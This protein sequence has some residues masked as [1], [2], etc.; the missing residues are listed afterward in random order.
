MFR[1]ESG[2]AEIRHRL[3]EPYRLVAITACQGEWEMSHFS[4]LMIAALITGMVGFC[5]ALSPGGEY[6]EENIGLRLLFLNRGVR[7]APQEV[8]LV[9]IDEQT[10]D[11]LDMH[12]YPDEWP[13]SVHSR[14]V[15]S[16]V[17]KGVAAIAFDLFFFESRSRE[18]DQEFADTLRSA[19]NVVL[20]QTLAKDMVSI[21]NSSSSSEGY[22]IAER[23][24]SPLPMFAEAAA[25]LAPFP[26][27]K[28]PVRV[29]QFW[30]FRE[31][32]SKPTL[33]VM[34]F[35]IYAMQVHELFYRLFRE[36]NPSRAA[37]F[38]ASVKEIL[39]SGGLQNFTSRM[40][41]VFKADPHLSKRMLK[42]IGELEALGMDPKSIQIL[43]AQVKIYQSP[44]SL[45]INY[46][47]PP[48]TVT[49]IP[50][51]RI[52]QSENEPNVR[53][54]DETID[55]KGKVAFVGLAG[56]RR[57]EQRDGFNT[58]FSQS[59]GM[60]LSGV[61]IAATAFANILEDMPVRPLKTVWIVTL[62]FC[63]GAAT[64]I[65]CYL[66]STSVGLLVGPA[67]GV[68]YFSIASREF[69]MYA[70][71]YPIV[72]PLL[73]QAPLAFF[74]VVLWKYIDANHERNN[75]RR[76]FG[77]FLP[78]LIVDQLAKDLSAMRSINQTVYGVCLHTD[79]DSYVTLS[80]GMEPEVLSAFLNRYYEAVFR[81]VKKHGGMVSDI[82]G[83]SMMAVWIA[84]H[85]DQGLRVRSCLAALDIEQAVRRFNSSSSKAQLPTRIG[86]HYGLISIG[87]IG[88]LDHYEYRPVGDVVNTAAR[89][90]GLNK[91]LGTRVLV[92]QQVIH[93]LDGFLTR[94]VGRF[95]LV[96]KSKPMIL[97][98]LMGLA[99]N[100]DAKMRELCDRFAGGLEAFR[101]QSW[102]EGIEIFRKLVD[103]NQDG[104][105]RFYLAL[106]ER[107]SSASPGGFWDGTVHLHIK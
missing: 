77:Y 54:G 50:Y 91:F 22:V 89:I 52:L 100:A 5:L 51:Y 101:S 6:L 47:G 79:G 35:Q 14:L 49:T 69:G 2:Q 39:A 88:G 1:I 43:R 4:K 62:V 61:E 80:E 93:Q 70:R 92:S 33:P 17:K 72:I 53:N 11:V 34:A 10:S 74:S 9:V 32:G 19:S 96:G 42:A 8:F 59:T 25:A 45:F 56:N 78:D 98:E 97:Y 103:N 44:D 85:P 104:P 36:S 29:N 16:L 94:E 41:A 58:V 90:E 83:D 24:Q 18:D 73:V 84:R 37:S 26:L 87:N 95:I 107:Y 31:M 46:Y 21:N 15:R 66:L 60:D 75:I 40:R 81:P 38:P 28:V 23:Y 65:A 20:C 82:V 105:S 30:T 63:W 12:P 7:D 57:P 64:A 76:A 71:W 99:G 55:L 102:A 86:L 68:A 27:P 48:R 67:A 106:C 13:H 3:S